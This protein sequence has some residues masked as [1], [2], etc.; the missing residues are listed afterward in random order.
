MIPNDLEYGLDPQGRLRFFGLYAANVID[1]KDPL[2]K[3]RLKLQIFQPTGIA[4]TVWAPQCVGVLPQPNFPYGTFSSTTTQSIGVNSATAITLNN[5]E[6]SNGGVY[7]D[8]NKIYVSEAGRYKVSVEAT[9]KKSDLITGY[10]D[11]WILKNGVN[12]ARSNSRVTLCGEP[13][14]VV[15]TEV[16]SDY[17][18]YTHNHTLS[19]SP[20]EPDPIAQTSVTKII[21]MLPKDYLTFS[22]SATKSSTSLQ[23]YTGLT[24]PTRPD[25]PS[26][27]ATLN[28]V[29]K[30]VP[31]INT[32]VWVM[33]EAGD[34]D[35]PVW[36]GGIA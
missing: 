22:A 30:Y 14:Y 36:M 33:F 4:R 17:S 16:G 7:L 3:G 18:G 6:D 5:T 25:I 35:Y 21:D 29:G 24:G 34:P 31:R 20:A 11:L 10:A 32:K 27:I 8:S 26:I 19:I 15:S 9:F 1:N 28:L 12:V 23:A 13:T 2:N